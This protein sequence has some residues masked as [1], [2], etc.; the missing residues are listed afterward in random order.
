MEHTHVGNM[1]RAKRT[2]APKH[3]THTD[4]TTTRTRAASPHQ[5]FISLCIVHH[6][7]GPDTFALFFEALSRSRPVAGAHAQHS[8]S[9]RLHVEHPDTCTH[10]RFL[11]DTD[12]HTDKHPDRQ[13]H[14]DDRHKNT[15][16]EIQ[17]FK[18]CGPALETQDIHDIINVE[19]KYHENKPRKT[20]FLMLFM[21]FIFSSSLFEVFAQTGRPI[22]FEY[23]NLS[24]KLKY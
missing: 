2:Q 24:Q 9:L 19:H 1:K 17:R 21:F 8:L 18:C 15:T 20:H 13:T 22:T 14:T 5:S 6:L 10:A 23:L 4:S 16:R 3:N 12:R 11:T 7:S